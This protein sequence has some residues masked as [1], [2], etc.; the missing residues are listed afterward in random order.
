MEPVVEWIITDGLDPGFLTS[1]A[2][3][4]QPSHFAVGG[5]RSLYELP[6]PKFDEDRDRRTAPARS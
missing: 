1:R 2:S 5:S 6:P 3:W 4:L